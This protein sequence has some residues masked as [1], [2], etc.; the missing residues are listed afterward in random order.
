[1]EETVH[2]SLMQITP[3]SG[4]GTLEHGGVMV[5]R[6][7]RTPS[8]HKPRVGD[9]TRLWANQGSWGVCES[10]LKPR[11]AGK[12]HGR[13][14]KVPNRIWETRLSGIIGGPAKRS[15]GGIVNP[16]CNRKGKYGNPAPIAGAR[17]LYPNSLWT[18]DI[19]VGPST[20]P[21]ASPR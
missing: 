1:L 6:G 7:G 11:Q 18:V 12:V 19:C 21:R 3:T 2:V 20:S 15:H 9:G 17:G 14:A 13:N 5:Q 8:R 10:A 16:S 4:K